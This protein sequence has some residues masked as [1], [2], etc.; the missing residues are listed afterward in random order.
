MVD[1]FSPTCLF[2]DLRS[3]VENMVNCCLLLIYIY[4]YNATLVNAKDTTFNILAK[5]KPNQ[6]FKNLNHTLLS[7]VVLND[8]TVFKGLH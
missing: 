3:L 2:R 5:V 7:C 6:L 1:R 4:N 8:G